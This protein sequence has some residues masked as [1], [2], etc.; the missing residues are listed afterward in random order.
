MLSFLN[1]PYP[2]SYDL[3]RNLI[4]CFCIGAFVA[5]F[6]IV[7]QPFNISLWQTPHKKLKLAGYGLVSFFIPLAI[8]LMLR[9][10]PLKEREDNWKVWKE[11]LNVILAVLCIAVGNLVYSSFIGLGSISFKNYVNFIFITFMIGIFP[12]GMSV[13]AKYNRFLRL[14][15]LTATEINTILE[16]KPLPAPAPVV[17]NVNARLVLVAENEKDKLEMDAS[18]LLYIESADNYSMVHFLEHDKVSKTLIRG[19]LKRME[20]QCASFPALL[21]CHRAFIVNTQNVTHI[22]G[23]AAGYKLSIKNTDNLVPVSRNYGSVVTG[24]L[25]TVN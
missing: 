1:K 23:N 22:E 6:L 17:E 19:S 10:L 2:H 3:K 24:K 4:V 11:I 5:F 25:K 8:N 15:Q 14:S 9:A 21:R 7:F 20:Q 13:I 18:D 12:I 16:E